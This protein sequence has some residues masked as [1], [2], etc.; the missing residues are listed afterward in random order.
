MSP[1]A[2]VWAA[3]AGGRWRVDRRWH[4]VRRAAGG[5]LPSRCGIYVYGPLHVRR[6]ASAPAE[7]RFDGLCETCAAAAGIERPGSAL[8]LRELVGARQ[9]L[10]AQGSGARSP[11]WP[12]A[13]PD[14]GWARHRAR[15]A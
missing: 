10:L 14:D 6:N 5:A 11:R 12:A 8:S 13:D 15:A 4:L 1:D 7:A 9:A 3:T 2:L